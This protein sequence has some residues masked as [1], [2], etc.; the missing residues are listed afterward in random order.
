MTTPH[1]QVLLGHRS[2]RIDCPF[3]HEADKEE[4]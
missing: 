3:T 2:L 4:T 1:V